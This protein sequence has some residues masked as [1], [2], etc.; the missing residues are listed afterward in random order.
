[1]SDKSTTA[2][3]S[4]ASAERS[5]RE[6][7]GLAVVGGASAAF[8]ATPARAEAAQVKGRTGDATT[9][10]LTVHGHHGHCTATSS[11][12][13]TS[14]TRSTTT[15]STT[16]S[17][18]PRSP[19]WSRPCAPSGAREHAADL[20]AGDTI[21]GTP[22][23]YYY[24][25]IDPITG[26]VDAPH[27]HGHERHRLRRRG[28]RQPR[29]QLRPRHAAR[30]R[31]A[32]ATSRCSARTPSTGTPAPPPSRR[33]SSAAQG[34]RRGQAGEGRHPRAGHPRC[35]HLGQGQRRGPGEVPAASSSRRKVW[36]PELKQAGCDVVVVACH[37]GATPGSSYGDALPFPENA[38]TQLAQQVPGID[39]VLV[40]HAHEEIPERL[41]KN[42]A[43]GK[44]VLLTEPLKWGMRAGRD[45]LRPGA[46]STGAGGRADARAP[47]STPTRSPRTPTSPACSSRTTTIVVT[48]VNSRDRHLHAARCRPRPP[49]SRTPRRSTSST[50]SR[51]TPCKRRSPARPRRACRCCRS[52]RRSTATPR[53]PPAT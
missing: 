7:L 13:T 33:T 1:M 37:S 8:L 50:T 47:C 51:P 45:G 6:M 9:Y 24:A 40:G 14:R 4:L 23:A 2:T 22:L 48:Y 52:R 34:A 19:R 20:D 15:R 39:A 36:V 42:T 49:G 31:G 26:G 18:W 5:R 29:V 17:A 46:R 16:T 44:H 25:K 53:S 30:L 43:T 12:G 11:T 21:Q 10:R 38:S 28:A 32:A 27:G 41:V 35:R 3:T